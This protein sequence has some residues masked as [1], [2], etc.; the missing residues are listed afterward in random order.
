MNTWHIDQSLLGRTWF[1]PLIQDAISA[2]N[3]GE[4]DAEQAGR[5][6]ASIQM[7]VHE[8]GY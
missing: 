5:I 2:L 6:L 7:A 4:I 3:N 1:G 8:S